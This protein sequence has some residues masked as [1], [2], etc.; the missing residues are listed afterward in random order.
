MEG[1][2]P[3]IL[4]RERASKIPLLAFASGTFR[5]RCLVDAKQ[6]ILNAGRIS[7]DEYLKLLNVILKEELVKAR[8]LREFE[9]VDG[10]VAE[11][12]LSATFPQLS[13][14]NAELVAILYQLVVEGYVTTTFNENRDLFFTFVTSNPVAVA[15]V[16]VPVNVVQ[17]GKACSGCSY[18]Q[19]ACP[20]N[21]IDVD[22][23]KVSIDLDKCIRCG[24]CYTA[25]PRSFLPKRVFEWHAVNTSFLKEETKIG[26][27]I[28][29]W[30]AR[31]THTGIDAVKQ[32]GG[33]TS[34]V[35]LHA[36]QSGMVDA[37][38]GSRARDG[39]PWKPEPCIMKEPRDV[40]EAAGTKYV[41]TP[42]LKLLAGLKST[43][44]IAVVGTPCMMQALRKADVYPSGTTG[45]ANIRY[46]IG[47]FCMESFTY[48]GIKHLAEDILG[49]NLSDVVKMDI[50]MGKF[51]MHDGSSE[52]KTA[53]MK[54]VGKLA[55]L[56]C[57]CCYDLTSEMADLSIGSIGSEAGWNTVL[58]RNQKGKELFDSAVEAGLIEKKP[59]ESVKPGLSLLKKL[60]FRKKRAYE[61][62]EKKR[63]ADG[64][65]H[66][67]YD[68]KLWPKPQ[69][70]KPA[71]PPTDSTTLPRDSTKS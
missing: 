42:S 22:D 66:P 31:T 7:E 48:E 11:P 60:S 30:T 56:G 62:T 34:S 16:Y 55:R 29:A 63:V 20:V 64:K 38:I 50:N 5:F 36:L 41:N 40:L 10:A 33:I 54:A 61:S 32:D 1:T 12:A 47:I 65:Y 43:G 24:L 23:G 51:F 18:C 35:V 25:C 53:E 52:P 26:P 70:K 49:V 46:R 67:F 69:K 15:P 44:A 6:D 21:C 68:M 2:A 59:L 28:E 17:D 4:S 27:V 45:V 3:G 14:S 13:M 37:A 71:P 19:V 57:H 39:V 8:V 58:I 9:K